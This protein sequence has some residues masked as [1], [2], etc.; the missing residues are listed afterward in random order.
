[1]PGITGVIGIRGLTP[2]ATSTPNQNASVNNT[3]SNL[4]PGDPMYD[5]LHRVIQVQERQTNSIAET[6]FQDKKFDSSKPELAHIHLTNFK[7]HW[8]R[9][10]SRNRITDNDYHKQFHETLS[11]SAYE[12]V[13]G[14]FSCLYF[15]IV[16]ALISN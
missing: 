14:F 3:Q 2:Q 15:N 13:T 9:L 7:S 8:A 6:Q 16:S 1:M 10:K 4:Q 5:L 12:C 11:G